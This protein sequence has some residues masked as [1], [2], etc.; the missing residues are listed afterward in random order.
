MLKLMVK[1]WLSQNL[2]PILVYYSTAYFNYKALTDSR[3]KVFQKIDQTIG[4]ESAIDELYEYFGLVSCVAIFL[5]MSLEGAMNRCIPDDYI[6]E[7][8]TATKTEIHSK[9]QIERFF[10]FE[11]KLKVINAIK[12]KNF[13]LSYGKKYQHIINLRNFRD[14]IIHT[15][16][17]NQGES[18]RNH[19]Y[20]R[21]FEFDFTNA[22]LQ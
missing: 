5:F 20:R 2:I 17:E 3:K 8:K 11:N 1:K 4:S 21:A 10:S 22:C 6:H 13:Q 16:S 7:N 14:D 19:N 15:K 18:S 9:W 12:H